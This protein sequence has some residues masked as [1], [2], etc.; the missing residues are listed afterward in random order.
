[1]QFFALMMS[2]RWVLLAVA[3]TGVTGLAFAA[4]ALHAP[5]RLRHRFHTLA[6]SELSTKMQASVTSATTLPPVSKS[7]RVEQEIYANGLKNDWQDWGWTDRSI[8]GPGPARLDFSNYGGWILHHTSQSASFGAF[9]FR[10]KAPKG[11]GDFLEIGLY[12]DVASF[13]PVKTGAR[14]QFPDADGWVLV[15]VP[16]YELNPFNQPVDGVRIRAFRQ[17]AKSYVLLDRIALAAPQAGPVPVRQ[18]PRRDRTV[19]IRC[20]SPA[21]RV[22]P[23]IYGVAG[24]NSPED[25][26]AG[27][28]RFGGNPTSRFNWTIGNVWN[29]ADDWY[30][31]NVALDWN[32]KDLVEL[33]STRQADLTV[34]LPMLGWV[35]RDASAYSFPVSV[36]GPQE[37]VDPE[38]P[39]MG[40]G[41]A[42]GSKP[43]KPGD[44]RR[45][46]VAAPPE[47]VA[48][49]VEMIRAESARRGRPIHSYILDN[50]PCLWNSTHRDVHPEPLGY[51]EL[52]ERTIQYGAAIR[53]A[54][55]Q[56]IIAGP[57]E[58]GWSNYFWSAKDAA[59][60]FSA[61]P[62]RR[63]HGDIPLLDWY[64][65]RLNE[66]EKQ[67]GTRILDVVDLH[68]YPQGKGLFATGGGGETSL[69][70]VQ[71]RI[72]ATRALWDPSYVDESWIKDRIYLIPRLKEI[73][74]RDYPG[75]GISIGEWNFGAE[76]HIS[77]GLATA[78]V[79]GRF[80][81]SG[82]RSAYFWTAPK[83]GTPAY[84]A[85][86]A[87]RNFDGKGAAFLDHLV[88]STAP[89]DVSVF[90]SRD[91]NGTHVV[92]IVLVL[93][94]THEFNVRF[95][96]ATC[97]AVDSWRT[98][99]YNGKPDGFAPS[100]N[101]STDTISDTLAPYSIT[102][103]DI[104][105]KPEH[106]LSP[107][108]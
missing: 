101:G 42:R 67:T 103:L 52:L 27:A 58:W 70:A 105:F 37:A 9:V 24:R 75:R 83:K 68:F 95:D 18:F 14:Y 66:H 104:A 78:E 86:R 44:P 90:A 47:I 41:I 82:I 65:Q 107:A 40:N 1:M 34:T 55:P 51:D 74:A 45:T 54:D 12:S 61:K 64:L 35:A 98:L 49:W 92:A 39:D 87:Y 36:Y 106:N 29:T 15:V 32:W 81:E 99:S 85:F 19:I 84:W 13:E 8:S 62:D 108:H 102:V 59:A 5:S 56:A 2:K 73:I 77:G 11:F 69:D 3:V 53:K 25:L 76:N 23:L 89:E 6:L 46:S 57:A 30:Y 4:K 43:I 50:E 7:F 100:K 17:V 80:A 60:G 48:Q 38:H 72:R 91:A 21:T 22:S 71:R 63:A 93:S 10:M 33:A 26:R 97:G 20:S 31:R 28:Y 16:W 96:T 94:N 88:P 79:L